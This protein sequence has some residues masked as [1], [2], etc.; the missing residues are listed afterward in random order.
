MVIGS[1]HGKDSI[2][3]FYNSLSHY[4]VYIIYSIN[5]YG[6]QIQYIG[7]YVLVDG[8]VCVRVLGMGDNKNSCHVIMR[9]IIAI[10]D[11]IMKHFTD[12]NVCE[13]KMLQ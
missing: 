8:S 6:L 3:F 11:I 13:Q 2:L 7:W 9:V 4:Y 1:H 12:V 5:Y 10:I